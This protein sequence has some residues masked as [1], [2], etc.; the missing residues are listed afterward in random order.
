MTRAPV[1]ICR[2]ALWLAWPLVLLATVA[3]AAPDDAAVVETVRLLAASGSRHPGSDGHAE[4][5][6]TINARLSQ[7]G[8]HT[9]GTHRFSVPVRFNAGST[10]RVGDSPPQPLYPLMADAVSPGGTGP[11][12]LRGPLIYAGHGELAD[13]NGKDIAG[14]IVLMELDSAKNWLNAANLG[15]AALVYVDREDSPLPRFRDKRELTPIDFPRFV[16]PLDALRRLFGDFEQARGGRV[17]DT[18]RIDSEIRWR[19]VIAE[20]IYGLI[21]GVHPDLSRELMIVTAFYDTSEWVSGRS[22]GADEA[23]GIATLLAL[24]RTFQQHPPDRSVLLVA[25]DAHSLSL[26]GMREM[27]W[28]IRADSDELDAMRRTLETEGR[29]AREQLA[30][31]NGI[32]TDFRAPLSGGE[33]LHA[34]ISNQIKT[35]VD[36]LSRLLMQL[37]LRDNSQSESARIRELVRQRMT[38]R[39]LGW[40]SHY[41]DAT[42]TESR[43]IRALIPDAAAVYRYQ[44]NDAASRLDMLASAAAF[45]RVVAP[46]TIAAVFSLHLSS[47]GDGL[48]AFN[49]GWLYRLKDAV[50]RTGAYSRIDEVMR[51]AARDI[52][53]DTGQTPLFRDTLRPSRLRPWESYFLDRPFLGGEVSALAGYLG[54]SLVTVNDARTRWGTPSDTPEHVDTGFLRRQS[55]LVCRLLQAVSKAPDLG[56]GKTLHNGFSTLTGRVRILRHGELFAE[57]P[58]PE[59]VILGAQGLGLYYAMSDAAGRFRFK[60][61][62][63]KKHVLDKVV[64]DGYRFDPES[65]EVRWAI[66]KDLTGKDAYRVRMRRRRMETDLIVF[67]CRQT[68]IFSMLEPRSFRYMTKMQLIDGRREAEPRRYWYSRIDTRESSINSIY[69]EPGTRLKLTLSDTVLRKKM[70]LTH[71]TPGSPAGVGYLIDRWPVIP[72]T[73]YRAA[74]DMW[75]LLKPRIDV[76]ERL[77]IYSDIIHR[78]QTNGFD[79]L[80]AAAGYLEN[81]DYQRFVEAANRSWALASRVY[82]HVEGIQKDVLLGVLFYIALFVPFAYC[83]ERLLFAFTGIHKRIAAFLAILVLLITVIYHVHPAFRLAYS[84][85][86]VVLA[87]FIMG[88]SLIVTV[89]IFSRFEQEM[90]GLQRRARHLMATEISRWKAFTAAFLLGVSNLRRRPL[91]TALTCATLIVLTFT[92]M[93]F[94]TVKSFRHHARIFISSKAAYHGL[95]M[96]NANWTDLPPEALEIIRTSVADTGVMAP[97]AW[98]DMPDRTQ[99]VRVPVAYADKRFDAR[100][101]VGLSAA[102]ASV[103]GID[104]LLTSGRWLRSSDANAILLPDR[105]ADGLGIPRDR[106]GPVTVTVWGTPFTVVGTFSGRRFLEWTDLDGEPLTPVTFPSERSTQITEVELDA[107]ESGDDVRSFQSRYQHIDGELTVIV[108]HRTLMA[109]GGQLKSVAVRLAGDRPLAPVVR[110]LADRF[111]L[112]IFGGEADGTFMYHASDAINYS[113]VPHI[114]IPMVLSI[115][116][117]LNTM[118]GSVYERKREIGVYT[119]V[120]LAPLHVSFLF[121]AEAL[122]FAVLSVV[123]GYL[124]AQT[125]AKLFSGSALWSGITVN[126]SSLAGV[127]A[128]LLVIMVVLISAVYPS[129]VAAQVAIPDVNRSWKMPPAEGSTMELTLPF[130][131]KYGEYASIGGYLV[132]YFGEHQ[133]V[134]HGLFSAGEIFPRLGCPLPSS[135]EEVSA[136]ADQCPVSPCLLLSMDLWLAPFD[137]GIMQRVDLQ[138]CEAEK[139]PGFL[140]LRVRLV[141]QSGEANAWHRINKAFLNDVR[142]QLLVWRS[143]PQTDKLRYEKRLREAVS[144]PLP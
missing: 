86:V 18:V 60:G 131:M 37:R 45:R 137:F 30:V 65:G 96:K 28:A 134:S 43:L 89:I 36:R 11:D 46:Y 87:F 128:M 110:P 98:L 27:I 8:I 21:P 33:A 5:V 54:V 71:A 113:G 73:A 12:G 15:A 115:L 41:D 10:L 61:V 24:A 14:A 67:P 101:M 141:R 25:T 72:M 139:D 119:S 66:D 143:L 107:I 2:T 125:S 102:E 26:A 34:A 130:M 4:A 48:G 32:P 38:L 105:L 35:E 142:K 52:E 76:L 3:M 69:L 51:Q 62:A 111:G 108:P 9:T 103:T 90:A 70:I 23:S 104:R 56:S 29:Q 75:A 7:L 64:I 57:Q 95:L 80:N 81:R 138:F 109:M 44:A 83:L 106:P 122:A 31:L 49:Q 116:I 39:R 114:L 118:I 59:T 68:T 121:I 91:R 84:P 82:D 127:G 79:A 17:A 40:R 94:T 6:R 92:I 85:M 58:A 124:L 42:E 22:P 117:V 88:L 120:G 129:R 144:E 126:Y 140:E 132:N 123:I 99:S 100:G 19:P 74:A 93:S 1:T 136:M 77:G 63:D 78:L 13:L 16:L 97:R 55:R 112:Y 135:P 133:D 50:N 47:H 53:S 20:N